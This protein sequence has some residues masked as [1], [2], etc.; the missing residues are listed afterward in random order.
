M[1]QGLLAN[2]SVFQ[3]RLLFCHFERRCLLS[4]MS[5]CWLSL[6][7]SLL[8]LPTSSC[9]RLSLPRLSFRDCI[10]ST[11]FVPTWIRIAINWRVALHCFSN[12]SHS[13]TVYSRSILL[14]RW[15]MI[16][17]QHSG[18]YSSS[19][20][21]YLHCQNNCSRGFYTMWKWKWKISHIVCAATSS[22]VFLLN[23][24]LKQKAFDLCFTPFDHH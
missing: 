23:L 1:G 3:H 19:L 8:L 21:P 11:N 14:G 18:A 22:L 7:L 13:S 2:H 12:K 6:A 5:S 15:I 10:Y 24:S 20:V 17:L 4:P 9:R 16:Y